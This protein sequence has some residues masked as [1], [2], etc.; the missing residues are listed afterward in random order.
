[1]NWNHQELPFTMELSFNKLIEKYEEQA[2]GEDILLAERAQ[3]V[4]EV[5][6]P[7]PVLRSGFIDVS[8]L[9]K[10]REPIQVILQ[11]SFAP[12]L[13]ENEIK[14]ATIPFDNV[15][16]NSS[17][18]FKKI[19]EE[20]GTDFSFEMRHTREEDMYI[21]ACSFILSYQ[22]NIDLQF[23]SPLFFDVPDKNGMIKTYRIMYNADFMELVSTDKSK[24]ISDEDIA[25]LLDNFENIELWKQHFPPNSWQAKGFIIASMFD[26]TLENSISELKTGLLSQRVDG[27]FFVDQ[28]E[29]IFQSIFN[30]HDLRVG[31]VRFDEETNQFER[32]FSE[33]I[34]S[35]LL[36]DNTS[37]GCKTSLC[38][39]S[40]EK[41][42]E[43]HEC[44]A[45]SDVDKYFKRSPDEYEFKIFKEQGIKSVILAPVVD[46]RE[47][48]GVLEL[49]SKRT[50]ELNSINANKLKDVMPYLVAA[51][52]RSKEEYHNKIEAIIQHECTSIHD[53]VYWR[54][55]QE[56][57]RF[58]K[59]NTLGNQTS[60]QEIVF[61][62]VYPLYGQ[63]D[64]K[65]SSKAR[66]ESI[67]KDLMI[68][69]S[70]VEQIFKQAFEINPLPIYEELLFRIQPYLTNLKSTLHTDTEQN[71][72]D[73]LNEEVHPFL[74]HMEGKQGSLGDL[75]SNYFFQIDEKSGAIYDHRKNYDITVTKINK[76]LASIIDKQQKNAQAMYPHY[77]E[78]YKT[79]GVEHNM[80]IGET[81]TREDSFN[82]LYLYNLR[83]W[84]LQVMCEMEN[85]HYNLLPEL[86]IQLDVASLLLVYN[87]PLSIRFRMDEKQF[88]VD[89]TYNARY[90]ILKKRL[91]KAYIKGTKK[92][93]T[94]K[95]KIAI[96][97]SQKKDER[98]YMRYI[99][100]LQSKQLLSQNVE[101][102][103]LEGLQGV[104]G[105]KA[106]KVEVLYKKKDSD[107]IFYTYDDLIQELKN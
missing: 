99:K 61:N 82:E 36:K 30:I 52:V 106:I 5:Q 71:I 45:I 43:N 1:M 35:F 74:R 79:D 58:L 75:I 68:Q 89:G 59:D 87:S 56:A 66:N 2:K 37:K 69:L 27:D 51:T 23:K 90:E 70:L 20:A 49:V 44:F 102:I 78:R 6:R 100:F 9:E 107:K 94:E 98:E 95:G 103:E 13:T 24:E 92:R 16:F 83:L 55:E 29:R 3:K 60:F 97:Y 67:R 47:L 21:L 18:R 22:Y 80:Y 4:L 15:V 57:K 31:F 53:S 7:Y 63:I 17:K 91:D 84:Q 12:V 50:R 86:P 76:R 33:N 32:D 46:G 19:M 93:L 28:F 65:D 10:Y 77:F 39:F 88:D 41:L 101:I 34:P 104:S 48:L 96:V 62:D 42:I 40:Y 38:K 81:I 11:D 25:E 8:L 64:I 54:F 26:V 85:A 14:I 72:L 105:L 73:L